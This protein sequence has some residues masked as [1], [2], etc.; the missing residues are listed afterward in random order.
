MSEGIESDDIASRPFISDHYPKV[1]WGQTLLILKTWV[2]DLSDD[3]DRSDATVEKSTS[4]AFD[5]LER[6]LFDSG[7]DLAKFLFSKPQEKK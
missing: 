1:L 6:G 7:F 5:L 3:F 4:F 2:K